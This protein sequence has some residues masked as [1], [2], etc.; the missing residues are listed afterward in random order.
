MAPLLAVIAALPEQRWSTLPPEAVAE[1]AEL[2]RYQ[3]TDWAHVYC[4][5]VKWEPAQNK[6]GGVYWK[7]HHATVTK[8]E[9][10]SA[11]E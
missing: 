4:S 5:V 11:R 6:T 1:V 10:Q 3:P 2:L 9:E 8:E 7:Y